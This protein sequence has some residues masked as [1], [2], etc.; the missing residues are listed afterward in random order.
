MIRKFMRISVS[1]AAALSLLMAGT[2]AATATPKAEI[3]AQVVQP[4]AKKTVKSTL[5]LK[6]IGTKTVTENTVKVSPSY[7]LTGT[8]KVSSS[9]LT[10]KQGKKTLHKNKKSVNLKPGKYKVSQSVSYKTK[11]SGK[12]SKAK[13]AKK[14]QDL[15][16]KV[17]AWQ[18]Y[19]E[20]FQE[21]YFD[22]INKTRK[23][24]KLKPLVWDK[25]FANTSFAKMKK[26]D[27]GW[28]LS[29][30]AFDSAQGPVDTRSAKNNDWYAVGYKHGSNAPKDKSF[31]NKKITKVGVSYYIW[32][33]QSKKPTEYQVWAVAK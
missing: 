32:Y 28:A 24:K 13:V 22:G 17:I 6:N 9:T 10:V 12:W 25:K 7:K 27:Y 26:Q 20:G 19:G 11:T 21:A 3:T 16:V 8:V 31:L 23:S 15:T 2:T 33:D 18:S 5:T 4:A 29:Q 1:A 14:T 30:K